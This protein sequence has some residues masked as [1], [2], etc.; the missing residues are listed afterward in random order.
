[1]RPEHIG[2]EVFTYISV[3]ASCLQLRTAISDVVP[4]L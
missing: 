3:E 2:K 4:E 1:L